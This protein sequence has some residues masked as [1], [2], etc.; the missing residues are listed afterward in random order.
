MNISGAIAEGNV[1]D[2]AAYGASKA[3]ARA[4]GA[5]FAREARRWGVRVLDA[6]PPHAETGLAGR[7]L[8]SAAPRMPA[9]REP[10]G[11]ARVICDAM[12]SGARD[13]PSTT[14]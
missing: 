1:T 10:A 11:I 5:A 8:E 7:A 6:R 13:L 2:M 3:A 9:G 4:F 12:E 14:S